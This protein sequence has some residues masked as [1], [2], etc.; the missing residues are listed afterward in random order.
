MIQALLLVPRLVVT[1]P[2]RLVVVPPHCAGVRRFT[3]PG[4]KLG[5]DG[6]PANGAEQLLGAISTERV[7]GGSV[8]M[9]SATRDPDREVLL[10]AVQQPGGPIALGDASAELQADREVVL[11][12]VQWHGNALKHAS[13]ELRA[14]REVVLAAVQEWGYALYHASAELQAD[15]GEVVLAAV[16]RDGSALEFASAELRADHE[17]V[18][19]AVRR[20]G[21][22]ALR[23]ASAELKA[24]PKVVLAA[25]LR[26]DHPSGPDM[27]ICVSRILR[28]TLVSIF[29]LV[30][31]FDDI[32]STDGVFAIFLVMSTCFPVLLHVR[33]AL[34]PAYE[35][36]Q[37]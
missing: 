17:V 15:R 5:E 11:T 16:Q 13:A 28:S 7:R 9:C 19:A 10:A 1:P 33:L 34:K 30:I 8:L 6:R 2:A 32:A 36:F 21:G 31:S 23:H 12:A 29:F 22:F 26:K 27:N 18:L 35:P 14:G 25:V 20:D 37:D 4:V 24:D 3:T